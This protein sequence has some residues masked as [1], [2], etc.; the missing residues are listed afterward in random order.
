MNTTEY[1]SSL[2]KIS[3]QDLLGFGREK[4]LNILTTFN[5][6]KNEDLEKF[7]KDPSKS[8]CFEENHTTRTYLFLDDDLNL[9]AYYTITLKVLDTSRISSKSLIKRL[10]GIDKTRKNIPCYLIAQLG[11]NTN[12]KHK[13]GQYLLDSAVQTI[14]ESKEL[15]GGRFILLDSVNEKEVIEFYTHE[16]N[17]F[18]ELIEPK[19]DDK[20]VTLYYPLFDVAS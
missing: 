3:L 13:I 16:D 7:I 2:T 18:V 12:C 17:G 8:V 10:D 15:V 11:K 4:V 6:N 1:I 19:S 5:C 9:I 20:N 14:K